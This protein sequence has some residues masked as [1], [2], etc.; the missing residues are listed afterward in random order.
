MS[1]ASRRT[2]EPYLARR[3]ELA[4]IIPVHYR[5]L[6]NR[7]HGDLF[8]DNRHSREWTGPLRSS[9]GWIPAKRTTVYRERA[10]IRP[11]QRHRY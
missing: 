1:R 11:C 3:R 6:Q 9:C 8:S 10:R 7:I 5:D 2:L 4:A